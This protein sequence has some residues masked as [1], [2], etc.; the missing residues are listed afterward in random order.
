MGVKGRALGLLAAALAVCQVAGFLASSKKLPSTR[1]PLRL[2]STSED[3][4]REKLSKENERE[5]SDAAELQKL[6]ESAREAEEAGYNNILGERPYLQVLVERGLEQVDEAAEKVRSTVVDFLED[7]ESKAAKPGPK[8]KAERPKVV[9]LGTGWASHSLLKGIDAQKKAAASYGVI[10]CNAGLQVVISP[11]NYF[12]FTPMLAGAAVGTVEDRSITEPIRRVNKN[13]DY[14]EATVTAINP[15]S[16][17]VTCQSI[18]CEGTA[19][20]IEEF[21]VEYDKLVIGVGATTN[22]FGIPGVK[23]HCMFLKQVD[24]ARRIRSAIGNVFER[25]NIPSLTDEQREQA[26]TFVTIGAGPTGIVAPRD[27]A[28]GKEPT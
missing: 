4:L 13:A 25:A 17:S 10:R 14:L 7:A 8:P 23:E 5:V 12:L 16:K 19:C 20:D 1:R 6:A 3:L 24:D 26:L 21:D 15:D 22:T 18:V 2:Y 27:A 9:V 28:P 11:R